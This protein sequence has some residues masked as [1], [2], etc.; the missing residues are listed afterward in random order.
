[1]NSPFKRLNRYDS[2]LFNTFNRCYVGSGYFSNL[3]YQRFRG[4]YLYF[5]NVKHWN[6][7]QENDQRFWEKE[8]TSFYFFSPQDAF[9]Y[10]CYYEYGI[11][12][13][14]RFSHRKQ[15]TIRNPFYTWYLY[16]MVTQSMLRT[17]EGKQNL[18]E[19]KKICY[20][21]QTDLITEITSCVRTCFQLPSKKNYHVVLSICL[22]M[23]LQNRGLLFQ[24]TVLLNQSNSRSTSFKDKLSLQQI[25]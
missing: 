22:L 14:N 18:F 20:C 3:K 8:G 9:A 21:S 13:K 19:E 16:Q 2:I 11:K 5:G 4:G 6:L 17:Y 15:C 10:R 23:L 24:Q 1:M 25:N 12:R 7:A